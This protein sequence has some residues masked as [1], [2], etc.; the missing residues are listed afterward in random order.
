MIVDAYNAVTHMNLET[1]FKTFT[2]DLDK[3]FMFS[4][5]PELKTFSD[6]LTYDHS[7][8][9]YAYV[10]RCMQ[11]YFKNSENFKNIFAK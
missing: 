7:G 5:T 9:S 11:S 8:S 10:C 3:G 1:F 2:P 6:A 4:I